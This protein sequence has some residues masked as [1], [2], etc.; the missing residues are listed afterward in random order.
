MISLA[1]SAALPAR[2]AMAEGDLPPAPPVRVDPG[3]NVDLGKMAPKETVAKEFQIFNTGDKPLRFERA[4]GSC[5]CIKGAVS[6]DP[7]AP[8]ESATVN[9]TMNAIV[10]RGVQ[11]KDL[12]IFAEGYKRPITIHVE[13]TIVDPNPIENTIKIEPSK[14]DSGWVKP[15]VP[16]VKEVLLRN[17]GDKPIQFARV[18][19]TCTCVKGELLDDLTAP[20][21]TARLKVT[22]QGKDIGPLSQT[23]TIWFVGASVPLQLPVT[24]TVSLPIKVDPFFINLATAPD[25]KKAGEIPTTGAITLTAIDDIPFRVLKAGGKAPVLDPGDDNKPAVTHVVHWDFTNVADDQIQPWWLIET[26]HPTAPILDIRVIHMALIR[27]MVAAQGPWTLAPDRIVVPNLK[28]GGMYERTIKLI[29]AKSEAIDVAIESPML[30]AEIVGDTRIA[31]GL[32]ATLH[33]T[34]TPNARGLIRTKL[35]VTVDGT[36]Q[37]SYLFVRIDS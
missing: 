16:V 30:R 20:G 24:A 13:A 19:T 5:S 33:I 37:S 11:K 6:T 27:K 12:Y 35:N 10:P 17:T 1:F 3:D 29:R 9:L 2:S 22:I 15:G 18:S 4:M 32:E 21:E 31:N 14:L 25:G 28:P 34:A 36:T 7:I 23:L 26:D 8:G